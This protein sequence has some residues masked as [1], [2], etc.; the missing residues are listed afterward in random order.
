MMQELDY[1]PPPPTAEQL[2]KWSGIY[3]SMYEHENQLQ[4]HR[5]S[6]YLTIQGFSLGALA[7]A[8][9]KADTRIL[10][11]LFCVL[12]A[13]ISLMFWEGINVSKRAQR[14]LKEEWDMY[15]SRL[16]TYCGPGIVAYR[17]APGEIS[18]YFRPWRSLPLVFFITW[19]FIA[20]LNGLRP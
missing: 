17:S 12:G 4:N 7:F 3:R 19:N 18:K 2:D 15:R 6:W 1:T 11:Y 9:D 20:L 8:W 5:L 13:I 16:S 14:G 10:I